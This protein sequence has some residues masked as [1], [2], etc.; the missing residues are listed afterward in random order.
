MDRFARFRLHLWSKSMLTNALIHTHCP[1][2]VGAHGINVGTH[3][4]TLCNQHC[5]KH[6]V[7]T[8]LEQMLCLIFAHIYIHTHTHTSV[9]HQQCI[10][11][12]CVL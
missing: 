11:Q 4:N 3:I 1:Q 10:N 5:R 12:N 9:Y 7:N 6:L 8:K 2:K